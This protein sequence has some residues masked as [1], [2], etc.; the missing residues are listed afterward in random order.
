MEI[1]TTAVQD[2]GTMG[3]SE[4]NF[5]PQEEAA[6][7]GQ[8]FPC[9]KVYFNKGEIKFCPAQLQLIAIAEKLKDDRARVW[10]INIATGCSTTMGL[11]SVCNRNFTSSFSKNS[12]CNRINV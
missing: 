1:H 11:N 7:F 10:P 2:H 3:K 12:I 4:N 6:F 5:S 8:I 9:V